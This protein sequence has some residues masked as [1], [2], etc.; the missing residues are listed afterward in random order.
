MYV[1]T[2]YRL[3]MEI[4]KYAYFIQSPSIFLVHGKS[5]SDEGIEVINE[6][7]GTCIISTAINEPCIHYCLGYHLEKQLTL[8]SIKRGLF[9]L[10]YALV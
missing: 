4:W 5:M 2:A 7:H 1:C 9:E 3:L 6:V 8:K 10:Q